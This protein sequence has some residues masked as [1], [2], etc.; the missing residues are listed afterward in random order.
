MGGVKTMRRIV[1]GVLLALLLPFG[2]AAEIEL[3]AESKLLVAASA[4]E[5]DKVAAILQRRGNPDE[6]DGNGK[7]ALIYAA[8]A[9]NED[10]I[11]LIVEYR[12]RVDYRDNFGNTAL[13]YAAEGG[14]AE[15][16]ET[17]LELKAGIDIAN[18]QGLTPLIAAASRGHAYIVPILLA[19]GADP[20]RRDF[21]GRSALM[22][23][24]WSR[25]SAAVRALKKAGVRE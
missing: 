2:A 9:G 12:A 10:M 16:V 17:L 18:R 3:L 21:T 25:K 11:E 6:A 22:W 4:G 13:Y 14:H 20:G 15:A 8:L 23:A 7:T 24:L 19:R 1:A 5:L